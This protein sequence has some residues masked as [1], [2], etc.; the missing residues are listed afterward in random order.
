VRIDAS[1]QRQGLIQQDS[2]SAHFRWSDTTERAG[3]PREVVDAVRKELESA[4]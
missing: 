1:A 4:F 2:Y 3:S